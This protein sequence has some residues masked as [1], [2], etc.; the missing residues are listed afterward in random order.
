VPAIE[1]VVKDPGVSAILLPRGLVQ[2]YVAPALVL[3][4]MLEEFRRIEE[5]AKKAGIVK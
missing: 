5:L 3:N 4:E 2:E 1:K